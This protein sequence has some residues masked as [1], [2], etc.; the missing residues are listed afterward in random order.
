MVADKDADTM[1]WQ[2]GGY[3]VVDSGVHSGVTTGAHSIRDEEMDDPL[4]FDLDSQGYTGFTQEQVEGRLC[5]KC[6]DEVDVDVCEGEEQ[7]RHG[8]EMVFC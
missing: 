3:G 5:Y 1:M 4:L 2:Q 7:W 8:F 6:F